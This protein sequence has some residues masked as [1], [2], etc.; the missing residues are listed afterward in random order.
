M[1]PIAARALWHSS[2][3]RS[4]LCAAVLAAYAVPS[5]LLSE[6]LNADARTIGWLVG[7]TLASIVVGD[8]LYFLA[9]ARIGV[10]R[11]PLLR[12]FRC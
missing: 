8:S 3:L 5:G 7:S 1:R 9:A 6:I 10:A 11:C 2:V 4:L 12:R